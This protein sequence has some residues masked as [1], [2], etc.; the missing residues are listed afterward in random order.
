MRSHSRTSSAQKLRKITALP[1]P[2]GERGACSAADEV[3]LIGKESRDQCVII[4]SKARDS[5]CSL[6]EG[7][8]WL[9]GSGPYRETGPEVDLN[10]PRG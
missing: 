3:A 9:R 5:E 1:V 2:S 8:D 4:A 6:V 7:L 10:T